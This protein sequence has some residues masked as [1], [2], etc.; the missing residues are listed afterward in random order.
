MFFPTRASFN[1]IL[2]R[3]SGR[4]QMQTIFPSEICCML[5][6]LAASLVVP[7]PTLW[8]DESKHV[9]LRR[10]PQQEGRVTRWWL[11]R[12]R[13]R[14]LSCPHVTTYLTL[15]NDGDPCEA[16]TS[17]ETYGGERGHYKKPEKPPTYALYNS[18]PGLGKKV[19]RS[20]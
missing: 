14:S 11:I 4:S 5:P 18:L 9:S 8:P 10:V 19:G 13:A 17:E 16:Q 7:P 12:T 3:I 2:R 20:N 15:A 1:N 6:P